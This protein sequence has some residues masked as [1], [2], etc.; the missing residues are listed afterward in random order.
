LNNCGEKNT[1]NFLL[2]LEEMIS[3]FLFS[4]I[5]VISLSNVDF[6]YW[7]IFFL[8]WIIQELLSWKY[9]GFCERLSG[10]SLNDQVIFFLFLFLCCVTLIDLPWLNHSWIL[11]MKHLDIGI[12]YCY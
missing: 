2:S 9:F 3:I 5:L 8:F 6:I 7:Y 10:I 1:L 12:W 11:R 4:M